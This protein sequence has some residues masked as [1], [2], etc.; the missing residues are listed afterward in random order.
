MINDLASFITAHAP[1][2]MLGDAGI[3][4]L[5]AW[6]LSTAYLYHYSSSHGSPQ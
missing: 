4:I 1:A 2:I 3:V 5:C 6:T